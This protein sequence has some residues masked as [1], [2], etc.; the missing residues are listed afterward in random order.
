MRGRG[1]NTELNDPE[2]DDA[3]WIRQRAYIAYWANTVKSCQFRPVRRRTTRQDW[4]FFGYGRIPMETFRLP[5]RA[6]GQHRCQGKL[7][8]KSPSSK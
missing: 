8:P 4:W 2:T 3:I 6:G 7:E 1:G 5:S